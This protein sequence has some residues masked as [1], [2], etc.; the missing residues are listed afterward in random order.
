MNG[1]AYDLQTIFTGEQG[2][3]LGP[4]L[5]LLHI[6]DIGNLVNGR[7]ENLNLKDLKELKRFAQEL[8]CKL[9]KCFHTNKLAFKLES[10]FS[11]F[12]PP[13]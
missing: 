13:R 10:N 8:I 6:N 12:H 5:F 1:V 4:I 2:S 11:I 9:S 7:T 3:V